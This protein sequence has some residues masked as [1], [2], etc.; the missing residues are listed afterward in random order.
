MRA[1]VLASANITQSSTGFLELANGTTSQRPSS[2]VDGMMRYN[3]SYNNIE[4]YVA[5]SWANVATFTTNLTIDQIRGYDNAVSEPMLFVGDTTRSKVL[6]VAE[7]VYTYQM[8]SL[9]N[10]SWVLPNTSL[11]S[12]SGYVMPYD[13]TIVR[14]TAYIG[15]TNNNSMAL[16]V[17]VNS[18]EYTGQLTTGKTG[19]SFVNSAVNLDFSAGN[20]LRLQSIISSGGNVQ[21]VTI[22]MTVKWRNN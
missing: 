3:T 10:Q 4:A 5:N 17:Y 20:L 7:S 8:N 6:S 1:G 16:A 15:A 14:L 11:N 2:P 19:S 13:G 12:T 21:Y 18:T 9:N 22:G